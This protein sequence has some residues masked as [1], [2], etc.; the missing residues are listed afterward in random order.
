[1][2]V[3]G[4]TLQFTNKG[5]KISI[6]DQCYVWV[7]QFLKKT[8]TIVNSLPPELPC[9]DEPLHFVVEGFQSI[10]GGN[11]ISGVYLLGKNGIIPGDLLIFVISYHDAAYMQVVQYYPQITPL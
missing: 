5:K 6:E 10:S 8:H 11:A 4:P 7:P 2:F 9:I 3:F 1:M